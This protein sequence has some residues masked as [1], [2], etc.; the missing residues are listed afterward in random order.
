MSATLPPALELID[1]RTAEAGER[2]SLTLRQGEIALIQA[3][4]TGRL[5]RFTEICLGAL[6]A[7]GGE[8]RVFGQDW[9]MLRPEEVRRQRARIGVTFLDGGWPPQLSVAESVTLQALQN[10]ERDDESLRERASELCRRFGLPGLPL[11]LPERL[12]PA[13]L[14][15]A[16]CARALLMRPRLLILERPLLGGRVNELRMPLLDAIAA[17]YPAACVWL[18]ASLSYWTDEAIP[19]AHRYRLG[20]QGLTRVRALTA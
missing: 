5:S 6:P 4:E 17:A 15:A 16:A 19:A 10:G 2:F 14:A 9:S 8:V 7:A 12:A 3:E 18:T 11:H 20:Q 1:V 13:E